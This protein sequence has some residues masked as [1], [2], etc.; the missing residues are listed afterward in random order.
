MTQPT[1]FDVPVAAPTPNPVKAEKDRLNAAARRVLA[2][3]RQGP[4]LNWE[5]AK[6]AIGGLRFGGR[7]KELRDAGWII[8]TAQVGGGVYRYTLVGHRTAMKLAVDSLP[9]RA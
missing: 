5:L 6:P 4:A 1:L 8:Q 2:R 9:P 7:L 3:L